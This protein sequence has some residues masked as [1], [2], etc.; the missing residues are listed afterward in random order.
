MFVFG[1]YDKFS[2]CFAF[3]PNL[4]IMSSSS[5]IDVGRTNNSCHEPILEDYDRS[6]LEDYHCKE[7]VQCDSVAESEDDGCVGIENSLVFYWIHSLIT[8]LVHNLLGLMKEMDSS[9]YVSKLSVCSFFL[10]PWSVRLSRNTCGEIKFF[11]CWL[12]ESYYAPPFSGTKNYRVSAATGC[13]S[14]KHCSNDD[15]HG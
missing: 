8:S 1:S 10:P 12:D 11:R 15:S 14:D 6:F 7:E 3:S 2:Q 13:R 4:V 5:P 9:Q